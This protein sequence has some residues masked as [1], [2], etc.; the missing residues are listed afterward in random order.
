MALRLIAHLTSLEANID[1]AVQ[2]G[3]NPPRRAAYE[4]ARL[5]K[6]APF[7]ASLLPIARRARPRPVTPF[8]GM[9][10]DIL[11]GELSA[12]VSGVRSPEVA[13]SRAQLLTDRVI[14]ARG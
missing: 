8:Y 1:M 7:I 10:T 5:V 13:L 11:Q 12:A 14:G 3:R 2:Y 9:L 4:D 6:D